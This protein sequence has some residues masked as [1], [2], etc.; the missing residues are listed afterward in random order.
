M[1]GSDC[2]DDSYVPD[3]KTPSSCIKSTIS[4]NDIETSQSLD[5]E[6]GNGNS[7]TIITNNFPLPKG[8]E[9]IE[10]S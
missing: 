8:D 5:I 3:N 2:G 10:T 4:L 7:K 1:T 6:D 9:D